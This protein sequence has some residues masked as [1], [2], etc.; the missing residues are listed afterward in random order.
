MKGAARAGAP[1]EML[2]VRR[3][4]VR[5]AR[6]HHDAFDA[7]IHHFVEEGPDALGIHAIEQRAVGGDAEAGLDGLANRFD[8]D[9]IPAFAAD[10]KIVMIA[11]AIQMNREREVLAR[12]EQVEAFP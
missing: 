2:L 1:Q 10:R 6:R 4:V 11:L 3:F 8:G 5:I 9:L 12:L 7:Q